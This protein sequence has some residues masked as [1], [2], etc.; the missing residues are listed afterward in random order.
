MPSHIAHTLCA[1]DT[2][3][4]ADLNHQHPSTAYTGSLAI[5]AQGPDIFYH[6]QRRR[7]TGIQYGTLMH[8][9]GYGTTVAHMIAAAVTDGAPPDSPS[10][11]LI[12]AFVTH[13]ILDRILHPY[14]NYRAGWVVTGDSSTE[15]YRSMHP[16]LERLIDV[17]LLRHLRDRPTNDFDFAGRLQPVRNSEEWQRLLYRGLTGCYERAGMDVRLPERLENAW[18][19]ALGFY[20][21]TNHVDAAYLEEGMKREDR[22]GSRRSLLSIVHPPN[23]PEDLDVLNLQHREWTH[24]CSSK[25]TSTASVVEMYN[26]AVRSGAETVRRVTDTW[27]S[28][29]NDGV[30]EERLG[31]IAAAVG[32]HNLSDGRPRKRP[33]RPRHM[34]PLPLAKLQERI[35]ESVR[36]GDGGLV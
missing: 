33:C 21:Y 23:V 20:E 32:D 16:F 36:R 14:I 30:T 11:A 5:G 26:E 13:A 29:M 7:P 1:E 25:R 2:L 3:R 28:M 22:S 12:S 19:D 15:R 24:P 10:G 6:N 17:A 8:R 4:Q 34:D 31:A 9:R 35:R 18:N 27:N